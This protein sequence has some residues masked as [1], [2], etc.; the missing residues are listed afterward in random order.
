M[1]LLTAGLGLGS[2]VLGSIIGS[3]PK[4][5]TQTTT[6]TFSPE[7]Q[8]LMSQLQN[9]STSAIQGPDA[10][11]KPM[12]TAATDSINRNYA[13]A[14]MRLASNFASRG[15][16]SSGSFGDSMFNTEMSR[17]GDL[18][19]LEG[20]FAGMALDQK[21]KGASLGEQLLQMGR[22]STTTGTGPNMATGNGLM[23]A[24]NGLENIST[25]LMM[26][27]LLKGG[28]G[29]APGGGEWNPGG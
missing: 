28:G 20:K 15:Y 14:P 8:Q 7:L 21:N 24:G 3:K 9:Y 18:S 6:P 25:M 13:K 5:T 4:T 1:Q 17:E 10:G 2:S 12:K 11:L 27:K 22:G 29:S 16:G 19:D 26:S 23:S